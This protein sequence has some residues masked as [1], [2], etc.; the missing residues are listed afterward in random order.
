VPI[1]KLKDTIQK[2]PIEKM[3]ESS[4]DK[5]RDTIR[6][7]PIDKIRS[8]LTSGTVSVRDTLRSVRISSLREHALRAA[9]KGLRQVQQLLHRLKL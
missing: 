1:E 6:R 2:V 8:G 4:T 5:L 3:F 7:V 9:L